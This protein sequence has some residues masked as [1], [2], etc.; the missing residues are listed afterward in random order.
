MNSG[1]PSM[2]A[3]SN[4][5]TG[6]HWHYQ[7]TTTVTSAATSATN[8]MA[9]AAPLHNLPPLHHKPSRHPPEYYYYYYA[10][11]A[12]ATECDSGGD[13]RNAHHRIHPPSHINTTHSTVCS[14][15][16]HATEAAATVAT[17][18]MLGIETAA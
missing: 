14:Y 5:N 8:P 18:A 16:K 1:L 17:A 9:T 11:D 4:A 7:C 15:G 12:N 13:L 6:Q 10:E 2:A 3:S